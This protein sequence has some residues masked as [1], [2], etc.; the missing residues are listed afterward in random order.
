M[1]DDKAK[2]PGTDNTPQQ[3]EPVSDMDVIDAAA[4][5]A[6]DAGNELFGMFA[7]REDQAFD[8]DTKVFLK[9]AAQIAFLDVMLERKTYEESLN[10][11][12]QDA[13]AT[14]ETAVTKKVFEVT[15]R[16]IWSFMVSA[17]SLASGVRDL[18]QEDLT[19]D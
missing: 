13:E 9:T 10:S 18:T 2:L 7:G 12:F 1:T 14:P 16:I 4:R 6:H 17:Q 19:N 15:Y 3:R 5:T 8:G 11:F